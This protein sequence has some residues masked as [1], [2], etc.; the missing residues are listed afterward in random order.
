M[1]YKKEPYPSYAKFAASIAFGFAFGFVLLL[2]PGFVRT[3]YAD[4][5]LAISPASEVD[6]WA[7][8]Q[9]S[10]YQRIAQPITITGG[11]CTVTA[12]ITGAADTQGSNSDDAVL[13]IWDDDS[14][15]PGSMLEEGTPLTEID[16]GASP[17]TS[18]F[19]GTTILEEGTQYWVVWDR[20]GSYSD[21]SYFRNKYGND[22]SLPKFQYYNGTWNNND[23]YTL[24]VTIEGTLSGGGDPDPEPEPG[25]GFGTSTMLITHDPAQ[26]AFN[27]VILFLLTAG[28]IIALTRRR[29]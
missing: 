29:V 2:L 26:V 5:C 16:A 14:G 24:Y 13:Q 9:S 11:D 27:G 8:G 7:W 6:Y 21:S 1:W 28:G 23:P 12:V 10:G 18:T 3:A 15:L 22:G 4:T 19:A 25:T 20:T 17:E